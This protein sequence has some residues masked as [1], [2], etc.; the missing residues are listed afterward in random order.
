MI[1]LPAVVSMAL[2]GLV[3]FV[4]GARAAPVA[5]VIMAGSARHT[6]KQKH[7]GQR[8]G[9][10]RSPCDDSYSCLASHLHNTLAFFKSALN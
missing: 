6:R 1:C 8:D 4:L 7:S 3:E 5:S 10:Q 2:D 9:R